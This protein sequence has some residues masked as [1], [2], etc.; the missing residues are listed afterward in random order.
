[1]HNT[2]ILGTQFDGVTVQLDR[3]HEVNRGAH[4]AGIQAFLGRPGQ[5]PGKVRRVHVMSA[6]RFGEIRSYV[7]DDGKALRLAGP[8]YT[9]EW[10]EMDVEVARVLDATIY[11]YS[12]NDGGEV[13]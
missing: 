10:A 7:L 12:V 4:F 2:E 1:M 5:I 9:G 8:C 3:P 6:H 13:W 11:P